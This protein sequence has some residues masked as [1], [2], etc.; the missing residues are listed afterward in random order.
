[1]QVIVAPESLDVQIQGKVVVVKVK[2]DST[3]EIFLGRED[4]KEVEKILNALFEIKAKE[5]GL[6]Q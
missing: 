5:L 1:M 3:L 4:Q 2:E 6:D